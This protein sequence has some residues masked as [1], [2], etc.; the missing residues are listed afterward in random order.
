ME[1]FFYSLIVELIELFIFEEVEEFFRE[2]ECGCD[3][4]IVEEEIGV[5]LKINFDDL[6][7][8]GLLEVLFD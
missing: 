5:L 4:D 2:I 1:N 3:L 6:F 8:F 7:Y